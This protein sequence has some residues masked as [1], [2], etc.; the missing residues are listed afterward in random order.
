MGQVRHFSLK[1]CLLN[2]QAEI[3][4][5][6]RRLIKK[7]WRCKILWKRWPLTISL[8]I[9]PMDYMTW[10]FVKQIVEQRSSST[11]I[12]K[13]S[14]HGIKKCWKCY[15]IVIY[16]TKCE[17]FPNENG[18]IKSIYISTNLMS[19]LTNKGGDQFPAKFNTAFGEVAR[20]QIDCRWRKVRQFSTFSKS[21]YCFKVI[22]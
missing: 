9:R 7:T 16:A 19:A 3:K 2:T 14:F 22:T 15:I 8:D 4:S 18:E 10:I 5:I 12:S 13:K 17:K 20:M 6:S 1:T 21:I 11:N